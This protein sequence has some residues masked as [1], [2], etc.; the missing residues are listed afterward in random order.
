MGSW[1]NAGEAVGLIPT[2]YPGSEQSSDGAVRLAR[3][4]EWVEQG[5]DTLL[6][7]GAALMSG[8]NEEAAIP[9]SFAVGMR[10][11]HPQRGMGTVTD[12]SGFGK[13]RTVKVQFREDEPVAPSTRSLLYVASSRCFRAGCS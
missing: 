2:R 6:T 8:S 12:I 4:T 3:R 5:A 10:V 7:T 1:A 11:K 9:Q 13:R